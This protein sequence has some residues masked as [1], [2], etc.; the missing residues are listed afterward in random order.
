MRLSVRLRCPFPL[1]CRGKGHHGTWHA[2]AMAFSPC[3]STKSPSWDLLC[4]RDGLSPLPVEEKG[5]IV[6]NAV[7]PGSFFPLPQGKKVNRG[8]RNVSKKCT[9]TKLTDFI[10]SLR[11]Y[12]VCVSNTRRGDT[13]NKSCNSKASPVAAGRACSLERAR[14]SR[15]SSVPSPLRP[16]AALRTET[17]LDRNTHQDMLGKAKLGYA[18]AAARSAG[19]RE[20]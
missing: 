20:A 14:R 9:G 2:L 4:A 19:M 13:I 10:P 7:C 18:N 5:S 11:L 3:L 6:A 17:D 12:K 15:A 8:H 16:A 1:A